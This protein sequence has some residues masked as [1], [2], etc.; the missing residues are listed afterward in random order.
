M[1]LSYAP[2]YTWTEHFAKRALERFGVEN[3]KLAKWVGR[4]RGSLTL[5]STE[6]GTQPEMKKYVSDDGI[7]F[8][9]NTLELTFVTCY[10][11]NY[12]LAEGKKVTIHENNVDLFMEEVSKLAHRYRLKDSQE[13][14]QSIS[15]H[16]EV[17]Y[18]LSHKIMTGRLTEKNYQLLQ[19]L[20][21]EFHAVKSAMRVIETKR[22]DFKIYQE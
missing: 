19:S 3:E 11:A 21:D 16:L 7:I 14:I 1:G 18:E 9:C 8:V 5:Y 2:D 15:E 10:E 13:M 6:S 20:I 4:Q 17:F 12:L 22:T